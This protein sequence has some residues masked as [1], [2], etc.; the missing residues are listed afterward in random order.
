MCN[1]SCVDTMND[2]ANCG[3]CGVAC[4]IGQTC[5]MGGCLCG[6]ASVSFAAAVQPIFTGSCALNGCHKGVMAQAGLDLSTA[7]KSYPDLVNVAASQCNDGRKRVSP[8]QPQQSYIIHK[9]MG[10]NLCF[11]TKM[12]K[13]GQVQQ[14]QVQTIS[15]WICSGAPNN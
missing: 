6:A 12:P 8:G 5:S 14:A 3:G 9:M 2:P 10:V 11:G 15:D 1:G 13:L 7:A 4:A